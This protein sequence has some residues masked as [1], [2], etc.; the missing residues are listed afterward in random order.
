[1]VGYPIPKTNFTANMA[2]YKIAN[3][4]LP[5]GGKIVQTAILPQV[6]E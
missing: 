5:F 2:V 1:M 6:I 3:V 4:I